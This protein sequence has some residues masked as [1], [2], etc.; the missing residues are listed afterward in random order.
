MWFGRGIG[1]DILRGSDEGLVGNLIL[2][3]VAMETWFPWL[4][5]PEFEVSGSPSLELWIVFV[6]VFL[7]T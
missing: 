2:G 6:L 5:G 4:R 7:L 1:A 3:P